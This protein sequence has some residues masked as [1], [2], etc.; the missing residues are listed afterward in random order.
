MDLKY[1]DSGTP[2]IKLGE[3]GIL[4]FSRLTKDSCRGYKHFTYQG[5]CTEIFVTGDNNGEE[6]TFT[7]ESKTSKTFDW[8]IK[9]VPRGTIPP[10]LADYLRKVFAEYQVDGYIPDNVISTIAERLDNKEVDE[11]I[12]KPQRKIKRRKTKKKK[13][14]K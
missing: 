7:N 12:A 2:Y 5:I 3:Y 14:K 13:S 6:R 9:K 4:S 8:Q 11:I 1:T 10:R